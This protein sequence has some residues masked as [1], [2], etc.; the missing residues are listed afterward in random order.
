MNRGG[1]IYGLA[2]PLSG[3]KTN[4]LGRPHGRFIQTVA[5]AAHHAQHLD[6]AAGSKYNLQQNFPFHAQLASFA[7]V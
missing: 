7:R 2:S 6:A 1:Y 5:Q 3:R 4:T